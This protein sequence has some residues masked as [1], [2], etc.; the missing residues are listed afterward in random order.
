MINRYT[1]NTPKTKHSTQFIKELSWLTEAD[2]KIEIDME[3]N[4]HVWLSVRQDYHIVIILQVY[5]PLLEETKTYEKEL[6][7][8]FHDVE[9]R[10]R[11]KRNKEGKLQCR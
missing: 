1:A 4:N 2:V 8:K 7:N 10:V 3:S 5:T 6:L 9:K 11:E